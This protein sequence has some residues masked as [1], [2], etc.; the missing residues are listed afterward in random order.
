MP[1]MAIF[2]SDD[3]TDPVANLVHCFFAHPFLVR[4][5]QIAEHSWFKA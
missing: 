3:A 4:C 1:L 2:V 5:T